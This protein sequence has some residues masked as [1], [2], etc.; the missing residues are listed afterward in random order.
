MPHPAIRT[1]RIAGPLAYAFVLAIAW[2]S[3][4]RP[5]DTEA[6]FISAPPYQSDASVATKS[7]GCQSCHTATDSNSM[8]DTPAVRLGC[9]DCHGGNSTVTLSGDLRPGSAAYRAVEA[10]A[11]V[12]PRHPREW[13]SVG[14]ANPQRSYTLL[15][16]E[17]PAFIRFFNPA[18]YRVVRESC[19]ACHMQIIDKALR[20]LMATNAM[21]W[22]GASYNNGVLP[23]K[24]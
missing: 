20:S 1:R 10:R 19:G 21:F 8:H 6:P 7:K 11:H 5:A 17:S 22:G 23:F 2:T 18:D 24:N 13:N 9:S 16:H 14:G 3:A 15:N 12:Q 4:A